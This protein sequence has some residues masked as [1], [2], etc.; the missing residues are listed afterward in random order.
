MSIAGHSFVDTPHG[1]VCGCGRRWVDIA[2]V[3]RDDIGKLDIAHSGALNGQEADE[4]DA[5]RERL[6]LA[7]QKVCA[8]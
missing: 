8:T 7:L 1:R 3:T 6:W 4:I 5:E 2:S